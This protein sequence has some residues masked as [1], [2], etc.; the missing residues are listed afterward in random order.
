MQG[1]SNYLMQKLL[2]HAS[3]VTAYTMP[4]SLTLHLYTDDPG[5]DD[6]GTEVSDTV[7]DTAYAA[8][9]LTMAAA[10]TD[11][12]DAWKSANDAV[13]TFAAVVY[14]SGAAPYD[15]THAAVKDQSG[16]LM[17]YATLP[18]TTTRNVGEPFAFPIGAI[19]NRL[20]RSA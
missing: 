18:A 8:Q 15:V 10:V 11:G 7:D 14:G 4:T 16:N 1:I 12:S 13:E 19:F 6:T 2:D 5:P 17:F 3:G 9:T 20:N